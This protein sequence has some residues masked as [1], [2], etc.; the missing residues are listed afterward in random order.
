MSRYPVTDDQFQA[1]V[2]AP[3]GYQDERWWRYSAAGLEW[4]RTQKS[5]LPAL[6]SGS[7]YPRVNV[8]W[9]EAMAFCA[10][11][12]HQ[13]GLPIR[14]PTEAEWQRAAQGDDEMLY[15]WGDDFDPQRCNARESKLR[16]LMPVAHYVD[17]ISPFGIYDMAGNAW[18]WCLDTQDDEHGQ[19]RRAVRG[20]SFISSCERLQ[21]TFSYY[22]NPSS[23]FDTIGFRIVCDLD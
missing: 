9:Y 13:T 15:P 10:W 4:Y 12:S 1:F 20:G 2:D 14:L 5:T 19:I 21:T 7:E 6:N 3:D 8:S 11:L 16:R 18:E 22:L 17:G 23:R